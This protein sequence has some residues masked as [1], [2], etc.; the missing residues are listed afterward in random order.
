MSSL[1]CLTVEGLALAEVSSAAFWLACKDLSYLSLSMVSAKDNANFFESALE[2]CSNLDTLSFDLVSVRQVEQ[3][4]LFLKKCPSLRSL[5]IQN[6]R[7]SLQELTSVLEDGFLPH[8]RSLR[9]G[10]RWR[11]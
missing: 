4:R 3:A 10:I 9:L 6:F 2:A 5:R 7:F 1:K 11:L 8:L